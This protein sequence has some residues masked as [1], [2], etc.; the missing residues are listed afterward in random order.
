MEKLV[1]RKNKKRKLNSVA[2]RDLMGNLHGYFKKQLVM[3]AELIS[4]SFVRF[5]DELYG[6]KTC[7]SCGFV[8]E[9]V[10]GKEF[11]CTPCNYSVHRDVN[12]A[13]NHVIRNVVEIFRLVE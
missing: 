9:N 13:R 7:G 5:D 6:S 12:G 1:E 10:Y 11:K 8:Q 4:D 2:A 3:K